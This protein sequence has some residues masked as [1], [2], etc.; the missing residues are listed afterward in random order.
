ML[1]HAFNTIFESYARAWTSCTWSF[2]FNEDETWFFI[3][4]LICDISSIFLYKWTYTCFHYFFYHLNCFT[5][6]WVDHGVLSWNFFREKW[7]A[8]SIV[9]CNNTKD[10]R[11][12]ELPIKLFF[13]CYWNEIFTVENSGYAFNSKQLSGHRWDMGIS[14]IWEVHS[15][16]ILHHWFSRYEFTRVRVWSLSVLNE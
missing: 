5:I 2:H 1:K 3:K 8:L 6:V 15:S 7:Q 9:I 4:T 16:T 13:F 12:Q 14:N 10:F 11:F